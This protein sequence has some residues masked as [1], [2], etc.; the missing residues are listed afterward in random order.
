M[1]CSP[2]ITK[3]LPGPYLCD[4]SEGSEPELTGVSD[5][6]PFLNF[7]IDH[8]LQHFIKVIKAFPT[9]HCISQY[10]ESILA[11]LPGYKIGYMLYVFNAIAFKESS[12]MMGL[13]M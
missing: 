13:V 11:K 12:Q 3:Y 4:R 1:Q 8:D 6:V 7:Q 10:R 5:D 2:Y 9:K